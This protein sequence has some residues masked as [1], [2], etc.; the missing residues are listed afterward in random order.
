MTGADVQR[1]E[2]GP[3]GILVLADWANCDAVVTLTLRS[4]I[5]LTGLATRQKP[6]EFTVGLVDRRGDHSVRHD[7]LLSEVAAITA[8]A[9]V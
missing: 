7:V 1:E 9:R 3:W 2:F 8:R 5:Q 4:G 6:G